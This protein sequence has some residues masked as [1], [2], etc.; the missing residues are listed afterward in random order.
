M[1]K[2]LLNKYGSPLYVYD[3]DISIRK[4]ETIEDII[5]LQK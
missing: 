4:R 1:I 3:K 2:E 5:N